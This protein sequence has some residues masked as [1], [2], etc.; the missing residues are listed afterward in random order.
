MNC[1]EKD[2]RK[3]WYVDF[4]CRGS[5]RYVIYFKGSAMVKR[6]KSAALSEGD[7]Q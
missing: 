1:D 3:L 4:M 6:L 7:K 5:L 2:M